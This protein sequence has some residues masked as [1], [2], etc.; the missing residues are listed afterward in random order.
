MQDL[1][2]L[3][4]VPLF[5]GLSRPDLAAITQVMRPRAFRRDEIIFHKGDEG[6]AMYIIR[7]GR[8]RI[9]MTTEEEQEIS[10]AILGPGDF[11][12]E[13]AILDDKPRSASA[14]A[15]EHCEVLSLSRDDFLA[16]LREHVEIA[17]AIMA[18]LSARL[19]QAD[20]QIENLIF[21]DIFGRV[22]KKLLDLSET[23]GVQTGDG[24]LINLRLT[25]RD[26]ASLV[27]TTRESVNRVMGLYQDK[28]LVS[29]RDRLITVHDP[30]AL[31]KRVY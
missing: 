3:S 21:L 22:A 9:F 15:M 14:I 20:E 11:F 8:V 13:L 23:H 18:V 25:Q 31:R 27:G 2:F 26:L 7:S 10:V 1:S 29:I 24:I 12:G 30:T 19:R 16:S 17:T 4:R 5:G 28:G 6:R